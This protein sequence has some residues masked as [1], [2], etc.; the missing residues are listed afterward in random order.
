MPGDYLLY[1]RAS[2]PEDNDQKRENSG[3]NEKMVSVSF[4]KR[5]NHR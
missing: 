5:L 2:L 1:I 3:G 4:W